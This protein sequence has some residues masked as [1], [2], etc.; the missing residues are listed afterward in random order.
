LVLKTPQKYFFKFKKWYFKNVGDFAMSLARLF[1]A[2]R[3]SKK[4]EEEK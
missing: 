3:K 2:K 4:G 1:F